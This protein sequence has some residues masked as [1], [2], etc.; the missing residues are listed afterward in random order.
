[1]SV[2]VTADDGVCIVIDDLVDVFSVTLH[3]VDEPGDAF[4]PYFGQDRG[5]VIDTGFT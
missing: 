2:P 5:K 1:M 3:I 4:F